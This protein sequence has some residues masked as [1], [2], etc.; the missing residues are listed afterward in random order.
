MQRFVRATFLVIASLFFSNC[1]LYAGGQVL[2]NWK[3]D[4]HSDTFRALNDKQMVI[5]SGQSVEFGVP[6]A[7]FSTDK[8]VCRYYF[9]RLS[10]NEDTSE[11][12]HVDC[13]SRS[14]SPERK[15]QLK[16]CKPFPSRHESLDLQHQLDAGD[17]TQ[18]QYEKKR[19]RL[20]QKKKAACEDPAYLKVGARC[21]N[22]AK[23]GQNRNTLKLAQGMGHI[24]LGVE[25]SNQAFR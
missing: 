11:T 12:M 3:A 4:T 23:E 18:E 8:W 2:F 13:Y 25:C 5:N 20:Y 21:S 1:S 15:A 9:T 7:L 24:L 19:N 10:F 17:L 22:T 14:L 16:K 6:Q